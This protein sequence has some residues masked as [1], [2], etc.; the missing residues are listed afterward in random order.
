MKASF[1]TVCTL[2]AALLIAA[3]GICG[4]IDQTTMLGLVVVLTCCMPQGCGTCRGAR[5]V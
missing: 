5:R 3:A 1:D 2:G 4:L